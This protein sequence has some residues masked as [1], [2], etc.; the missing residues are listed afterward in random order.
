[1]ALQR[2]KNNVGYLGVLGVSSF[3]PPAHS[4]VPNT[5]RALRRQSTF[6]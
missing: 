6:D 1:M 5:A 4:S 3:H 2:H